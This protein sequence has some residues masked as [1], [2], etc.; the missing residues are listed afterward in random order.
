MD[1]GYLN[2][3]YHDEFA[4]VTSQICGHRVSINDDY[5]YTCEAAVD[6]YVA[7]RKFQFAMRRLMTWI[8]HWLARKPKDWIDPED[9]PF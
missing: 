7:K 1:E 2:Q 4:E 8:R 3:W 5:C 6:E 9:L